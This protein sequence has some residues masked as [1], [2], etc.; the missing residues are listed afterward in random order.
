MAALQCSTRPQAS[1]AGLQPH[2]IRRVT[3]ATP[4]VPFSHPCSI[5]AGS[6]PRQLAAEEHLQGCM[7]LAG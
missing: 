7:P 3:V 2:Q 6:Q 1:E 5:V 4:Q